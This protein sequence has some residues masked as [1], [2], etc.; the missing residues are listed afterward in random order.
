VPSCYMNLC[1]Y[2]RVNSSILAPSRI[3]RLGLGPLRASACPARALERRKRRT[4]PAEYATRLGGRG[5]PSTRTRSPAHSHS[6]LRR[7]SSVISIGPSVSF[8][9]LIRASLVSRSPDT[10]P[11]ADYSSPRLIYTPSTRHGIAHRESRGL[12]APRPRLAPSP[13]A[14]VSRDAGGGG[15]WGAGA[16]LTA[17]PPAAQQQIGAQHA[18]PWD[19]CPDTHTHT[20]PG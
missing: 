8:G 5:R 6:L 4:T 19:G 15:A 17:G 3:A 18:L 12:E 20:T 14:A 2:L 9:P 16:R 1:Q 13:R 10:S 11:L 7:S